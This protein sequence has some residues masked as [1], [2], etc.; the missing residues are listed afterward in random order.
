VKI[1]MARLNIRRSLMDGAAGKVSALRIS[2]CNLP[3]AEKERRELWKERTANAAELQGQQAEE[4]KRQI[5]AGIVNPI[6]IPHPDDIV[7]NPL[8]HEIEIRGPKTKR[9]ID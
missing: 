1:T 6:V 7:M 8:T 9:E 4:L 5:E 3:R 2:M